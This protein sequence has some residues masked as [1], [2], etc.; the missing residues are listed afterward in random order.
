MVMFI[1]IQIS[2]GDDGGFMDINTDSHST[3]S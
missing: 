2:D 3:L 1:F